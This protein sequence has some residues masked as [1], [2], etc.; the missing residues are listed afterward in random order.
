LKRRMVRPSTIRSGVA[1]EA[2]EA[3]VEEYG[4]GT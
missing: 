2:I 4:T 3:E 1:L